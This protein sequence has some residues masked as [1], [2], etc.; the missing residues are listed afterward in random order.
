L[1]TKPSVLAFENRK[2][3]EVMSSF[4]KGAPAAR[5]AAATL[6]RRVVAVDTD[7]ACSS[8]T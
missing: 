4:E 2:D 6:A 7:T 5:T 8:I 1:S 3:P